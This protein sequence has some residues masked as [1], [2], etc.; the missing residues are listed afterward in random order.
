MKVFGLTGGIGSGKSTVAR[1]FHQLGGIPVLDADEVAR[2]LRKPGS[3]GYAALLTRF[4]TADRMELRN[5]LARDPVAKADLE[6]IL[7]PLIREES[8]RRMALLKQ[9]HPDAPF[10]IY[11]ATLLLEAGRARDFDGI[12]VVTSAL[13]ERL[14]RISARDHLS[15]EAALALIDAQSPDSFRLPFADFHIQNLGSLPDLEVQVRKILDQI[16]SP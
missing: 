14:A 3:A 4:V 15:P 2:D 8:S 6:A 9:S 10:L 7:H 11:E 5:L 16:K 12:M 13:P 1:M